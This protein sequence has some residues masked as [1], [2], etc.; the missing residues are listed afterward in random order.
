MYMSIT[1]EIVLSSAPK[2]K[3]KVWVFLCFWKPTKCLRE[4]SPQFSAISSRK[5]QWDQSECFLY[6]GR[7]VV[8]ERLIGSNVY[9][10]IFIFTYVL[11]VCISCACIQMTLGNIPLCKCTT[12]FYP[13]I[14]WL[15]F[16]LISNFWLLWI[17]PHRTWLSNCLYS[18]IKH[19]LGYIPKSGLAG[20]WGILV[21]SFLKNHCIGFS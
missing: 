17:Q 12:V 10:Y 16:K 8:L 18:R 21:H 13:F 20:S 4:K 5:W 2:R 14:H 15:M 11:K 1:I 9:A 3:P 6:C 19:S 7:G